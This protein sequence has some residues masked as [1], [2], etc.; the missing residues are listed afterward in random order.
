MKKI[1]EEVLCKEE[2][3]NLVD[4]KLLHKELNVTKKFNKWFDK[5]T[6]YGIE[7][8][9]DYFIGIKKDQEGNNEKCIYLTVQTALMICMTSNPKK[10][11]G[12]IRYLL[13]INQ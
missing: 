6:S 7:P 10:S 12:L 2:N 11:M 4:A 13:D 5:M 1:L 3:I 8:Q 9:V